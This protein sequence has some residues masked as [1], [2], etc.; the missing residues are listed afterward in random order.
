MIKK[1]QWELT[2]KMLFQ[3]FCIIWKLNEEWPLEKDSVTF[4]QLLKF[5]ILKKDTVTVFKFLILKIDSI[6]FLRLFKFF[7]IKKGLHHFLRLKVFNIEK[8]L[9]RSLE[10]LRGFN[11]EEG[12]HHIMTFKG[13]QNSYSV[14]CSWTG[15][16]KGRLSY[17]IY[18]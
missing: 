6:T 16:S 4:L 11:F 12:L 9:H 1:I 3:E 18:D 5:L 8:G 14:E 15:A 13:F 2:D 10:T 17:H 7:N